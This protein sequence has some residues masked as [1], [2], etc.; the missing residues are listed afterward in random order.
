MK[1]ILQILPVLTLMLFGIGVAMIVNQTK[2]VQDSKAQTANGVSIEEIEEPKVTMTI[3]CQDDEVTVTNVP[4]VDSADAR[5]NL[6]CDDN[7]DNIT[8]SWST[9]SKYKYCQMNGPLEWM[10]LTVNDR[11]NPMDIDLSGKMT[12]LWPDSEPQIRIMCSVG[13]KGNDTTEQ[14]AGLQVDVIKRSKYH[15]AIST[16]FLPDPMNANSYLGVRKDDSI[17]VITWEPEYLDEYGLFP[18][19]LSLYRSYDD[20]LTAEVIF[21]GQSYYNHF[22]YEDSDFDLSKQVVYRVVA[23]SAWLEKVHS[24]W[25]KVDEVKP[26]LIAGTY[27]AE[28]S[29]DQWRFDGFVTYASQK[30]AYVLMGDLNKCSDFL[31]YANNIDDIVISAG[32]WSNIS[33][34][35]SKTSVLP[36]IGNSIIFAGKISDNFISDLGEVGFHNGHLYKVNVDYNK[37]AGIRH[38]YGYYKDDNQKWTYIYGSDNDSLIS[39]VDVKNSDYSINEDEDSIDNTSTSSLS[40]SAIIDN[41]GDEDTT[42]DTSTTSTSTEEWKDY[43]SMLDMP[44]VTADRGTPQCTTTPEEKFHGCYYKGLIDDQVNIPDQSLILGGETVN[45]NRIDHDWGTEKIISGLDGVSYSDN[46]SAIWKGKFY[47]GEGDYLFKATADDG[48]K[49]ILDDTN[50][51]IY[52]WYPQP[53]NTHISDLTHLTEGYHTITVRYFE[54]GHKAAVK[55]WW[56][57]QKPAIEAETLSNELSTFQKLIEQL[58]DLVTKILNFFGVE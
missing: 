25:T 35:N 10:G 40:S 58:R 27:R 18:A 54:E 15:A 12:K 32:P 46:V 37:Y 44:T 43:S 13:S 45:G 14:Q 2:H 36:E 3:K 55:V 8:V 4:S 9:D 19:R 41:D 57:E 48:V 21:D 22:V 5:K 49:V 53:R 30:S 33:Y 11:Y 26:P 39:C 56:E 16:E 47:F 7:V 24:Q 29:E 51:L 28:F 20:G 34:Y 17:N 42:N 50:N 6:Q 38:L 52:K 23:D 1:K 31:F